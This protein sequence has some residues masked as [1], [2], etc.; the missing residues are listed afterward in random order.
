MRSDSIK[1]TFRTGLTTSVSARNVRSNGSANSALT[2]DDAA[3]GVAI[4]LFE[5]LFSRGDL[6][7][8][9]LTI[10]TDVLDG[11][12]AVTI[13]IADVDPA[14][15]TPVPGTKM[16]SGRSSAASGAISATFLDA[17]FSDGA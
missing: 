2:P 14:S 1:P 11:P 15:G 13:A 7:V 5:T 16:I 6:I 17:A 9:E 3:F 8:L 10:V 12:V 4:A